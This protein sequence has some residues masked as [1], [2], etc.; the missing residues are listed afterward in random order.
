[1]PGWARGEVCSE[2]TATRR[3]RP[4][5]WRMT[6]SGGRERVAGEAVAVVAAGVTS[7]A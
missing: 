5:W 4:G 1:V 7:P 2:I 3:G 6:G